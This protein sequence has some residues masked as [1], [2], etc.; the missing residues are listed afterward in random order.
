[1]QARFSFLALLFSALLLMASPAFSAGGSAPSTQSVSP[2]CEAAIDKAA[3][4]YSQCLLKASA[5]FAK[6]GDE[7]RLFAQ[8]MRCGEKFDAQVARAQDRFGED[9]CT[10]YVPQIA[11]RTAMYA[12][13]AA[14]EARGKPARSY[15]FVQNGT[16]GT[17]S[18]TTLTLTDV[19]P[20]TGWF[21]DR[22][23]RDAGQMRTEDFVL[24]WGDGGDSFANDP[25]NAEFSCE[26]GD[27]TVNYVVELMAPSLEGTDL[28]YTV[29]TVGDQT[30]PS[31]LECDSDSHLFIDSTLGIR[32]VDVA[33]L[34]S[35]DNSCQSFCGCY[36]GKERNY[37]GEALC[38]SGTEYRS[39]TDKAICLSKSKDGNPNV[40]ASLCGGGAFRHSCAWNVA[41][42]SVDDN[43]CAV[44]APQYRTDEARKEH[45]VNHWK[46]FIN[47]ECKSYCGCEGKMEAFIHESTNK[48]ELYCQSVD[49]PLNAT[50]LRACT[51]VS[52]DG[53]NFCRRQPY[54]AWQ[55]AT[56]S[57]QGCSIEV[58]KYPIPGP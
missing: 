58:I 6:K 46:Q 9:Q 37:H 7:D 13:S 8:Q 57:D 18:A 22:P 31:A 4:G 12:E 39:L 52:R 28:T 29:E 38:E 47:N 51:S 48:V 20:K 33:T 10:P 2:R 1:M 45:R 41:L 14:T 49:H 54:C 43:S 23:Y 15:L 5:K 26:V 17:L 32:H 44:S 16:G 56:P 11:D 53:E 55:K 19:S 24:A 35:G 40:A 30:L 21:T 50:S 3:G 36:S 34:P 25:P 27:E 42:F